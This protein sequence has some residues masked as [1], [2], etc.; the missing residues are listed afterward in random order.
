MFFNNSKYRVLP[1][2]PAGKTLNVFKVASGGPFKGDV[3]P[4]P[5]PA[6]ALLALRL[7]D[8]ADSPRVLSGP[9][10]DKADET[11]ACPEIVDRG[12]LAWVGGI[13]WYPLTA[14]LKA[15]FQLTPFLVII[16]HRD[17]QSVEHN[18]AEVSFIDAKHLESATMAMC[19]QCLELTR[20]EAYTQLQFPNS[21]PSMYQSIV[22]MAYLLLSNAHFSR[23]LVCSRRVARW[24]PLSR[25]CAQALKAL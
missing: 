10:P 19:R 9:A 4:D 3:L 7:W 22:L 14:K 18:L 17:V 20:A 8:G 23:S 25:H 5:Y 6:A 1:G 13:L 24:S 16:Q 11:Q 12:T 21:I 2:S 15:V